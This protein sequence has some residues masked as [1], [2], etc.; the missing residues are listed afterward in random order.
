MKNARTLLRV[1]RAARE[2]KITQTQLA[3][4]AGLSAARYWQIENGEG[5]V[6]R[7]EERVAIAG[8]LGVS[9]TAVAWPV[10]FKFRSREVAS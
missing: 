7:T 10:I 2:P 5:S 1:L 6:S 3:R 8:V 9:P 4:Q